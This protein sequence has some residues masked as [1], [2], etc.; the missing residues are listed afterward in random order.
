[1][2]H[3]FREIL[4]DGRKNSVTDLLLKEGEAVYFRSQDQICAGSFR[5]PKELMNWLFSACGGSDRVSEGHQKLDMDSAYEKNGRYRINRFTSEGRLCASIR[6][7]AA[8]IPPLE[9]LGADRDLPHYIA[10]QKGL[11]LI[12]GKTGSGKSTTMASVLTQLLQMKAWHLI[13]LEDPV[14]FRIL[15]GKGLVTQRELGRDFLSFQEGIKSAL[16]QSP[17]ILMIGEIRDTA[18]MKAALDAA[19]SGIGVIATLHSLGAA[20]TITRILQMFPGAERDFVRFQI[21]GSLNFIQSQILVSN[22][23]RL[24]LDYELLLGTL[25]VHN[26]ILEGDLSQLENLILLSRRQG[27]K[28]FSKPKAKPDPHPGGSFQP[29]LLSARAKNPVL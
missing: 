13:T 21:A 27:M 18:S 4:E 12:V 7:I 17:D 11:C 22:K 5:V 29:D 23:D 16:R 25:A 1:M 10:T 28:S 20:N 9:R 8:E 2:E 15:P 6:I 26:T 14:E 19:E 24:N 3:L